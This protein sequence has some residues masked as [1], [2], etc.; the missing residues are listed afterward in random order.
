MIRCTIFLVTVVLT[1]VQ[2]T[3][4]DAKPLR[5]YFVGTSRGDSHA[6][7]RLS[8]QRVG[9]RA[10]PALRCETRVRSFYGCG[11]TGSG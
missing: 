2:A 10:V 6:R 5:V 4:Q 7:L 1:G 8:V 11:R 3:A 9:L